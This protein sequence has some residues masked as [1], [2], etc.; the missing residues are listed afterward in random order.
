MM[1]ARSELLEAKEKD[2][3]DFQYDLQSISDATIALSSSELIE[4]REKRAARTAA[5]YTALATRYHSP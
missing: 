1:T 2:W 4:R 5:I 3:Q